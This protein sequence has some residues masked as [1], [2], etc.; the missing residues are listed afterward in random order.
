MFG[1][2]SGRRSLRKRDKALLS[3]LGGAFSAGLPAYGRFVSSTNGGK[4]DLS[5]AIW[6]V[7]FVGLLLS[8]V[9]AIILRAPLKILLFRASS[10]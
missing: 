2:A 7:M 8:W 9:G 4:E 10:I 3:G 1:M 5:L 6:D